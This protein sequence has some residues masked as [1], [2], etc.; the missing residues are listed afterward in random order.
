VPLQCVTVRTPEQLKQPARPAGE[1]S[2][3][4]STSQQQYAPD[5]DG[6]VQLIFIVVDDV[7]KAVQ[8]ETGI[9]SDT[10]IEILS[11]LSEGD[12]IVT[13]NYRAISQ[14]L[15]NDSPVMIKNAG[16]EN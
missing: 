13:G 2:G 15:N 4:D 10:H 8:V 1:E 6:F 5:K 12:V 11:G 3:A 7:A 16:N 14:T 9:Q